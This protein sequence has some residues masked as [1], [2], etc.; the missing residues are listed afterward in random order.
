[1]TL[2]CWRVAVRFYRQ[3]VTGAVRVVE[4][5][6]PII[7]APSSQ[8]AVAKAAEIFAASLDFASV[9]DARYQHTGHRGMVPTS[10]TESRPAQSPDLTLEESLLRMAHHIR[11]RRRR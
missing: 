9:G 10:P 11:A 6:G 5:H 7:V 2:P 8:E 1:M 3:D 4:R